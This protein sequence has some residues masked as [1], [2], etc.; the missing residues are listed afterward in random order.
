MKGFGRIYKRKW[1]RFWWVQY[2]HRGRLF[3]ESCGSER[4]SDAVKLLRRRQ[5]EM[6]AG[7]V[8]G[9]EAEKTT[10]EDLAKMILDDYAINARKSTWRVECS[11]KHL[12]PVFGNYRAIDITTDRVNAYTRARQEEGASAGTIF[13]EI[14]ALR[15]MFSLAFQARKI[16]WKPHIPAPQLRNIKKGF[17]EEREYTGLQSHLPG[18]LQPLVAFLWLTGWRIGEVL[19]LRWTQVDFSA[20]TIRIEPGESKNDEARVYPFSALPELEALLRR[21]RQA[22]TELEREQ[23]RLIPQVFHHR[24]SPIRNFRKAWRK[25]VLAAKIPWRTPHDF[26]RTAVRRMERAGVPR[27]TAMKLVGHKTE[28]VYRRYAIVAEAD[29]REGVEKMAARR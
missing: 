16:A 21:Q 3:R 11:L 1:T 19:P 15:R 20:G 8:V 22:T 29:L 9:P 25:A 7:R 28:T 4:R 12:R 23:E 17:F 24:G 13:Q 5:S 6:N 18:Y 26:R 14:A 10:F 2:G 27:S